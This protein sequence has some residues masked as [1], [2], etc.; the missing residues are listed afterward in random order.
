M[1]RIELPRLL[2]LLALTAALLSACLPSARGIP[3]AVDP[4]E[5]PATQEG[6]TPPAAEPVE[7]HPLWLELRDQRYG[8]GIALPCWWA[9]TPTPL[10]GFV[11]AMTVRSYDDAYAA[12]NTDKG[13][14]SD[15]DWPEGVIKIDFVVF[16]DIDPADS[17]LESFTRFLDPQMTAVISS[18]EEKVGEN[19]ALLVF[20]ED[21]RSETDRETFTVYLYRLAGGQLLVVSVIPNRALDTDDVQGILT[22]LA[23]SL[24]AD[25][26]LPIFAPGEA[27]IPLPESCPATTP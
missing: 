14:W 25:V 21:L 16:D 2:T 19:T 24:E 8:F 26:N 12:A 1:Y 5:G 15:G 7:P 10:E 20:T 13:W 9:V 6:G 17:L 4:A 23:L 18:R 27:I 22:S 11:A 3:P